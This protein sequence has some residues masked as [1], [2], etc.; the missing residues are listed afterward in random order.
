MQKLKNIKPA[1]LNRIR[2]WLLTGFFLYFYVAI[3]LSYI[4]DLRFFTDVGFIYPLLVLSL[5]LAALFLFK[6]ETVSKT[7]KR[8]LLFLLILSGSF[9]LLMTIPNTFLYNNLRGNL[10]R[11]LTDTSIGTFTSAGILFYLIWFQRTDLSIPGLVAVIVTGLILNRVIG[12]ED[13]AVTLLVFGFFFLIISMIYAGIRSLRDFKDNLFIGWVFFSLS[14]VLAFCLTPFLVKFFTWEA[15]HTT[16]FDFI[17][18]I[19]F[20]VAC[21]LMFAAMPFSNFIEWTGKQ[22]GLFYRMFLI[23]MTFL[24]LLF[25]LKFLLPGTSYQKIFFKGYAEM[26]KVYFGMEKY[27]IEQP[28]E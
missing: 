18:A 10:Y 14:L 24:L 15:A 23:P 27:E 19:F 9:M 7:M 3:S 11:I 2:S 28:E 1:R 20:L 17:G 13:L 5:V 16:A 25:S 26:E 4:S 6:S 8:V 12:T 21:L 22:K